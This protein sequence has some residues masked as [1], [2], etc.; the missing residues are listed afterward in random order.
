[1]YASNPCCHYFIER[2]QAP[3]ESAPELL[4]T[5][6]GVANVTEEDLDFSGRTFRILASP[7]Q[8]SCYACG[9]LEADRVPDVLRVLRKVYPDLTQLVFPK[10]RSGRKKVSD[11]GSVSPAHRLAF[12]GVLADWGIDLETFLLDGRYLLVI[13]GPDDLLGDMIKNRLFDI[14]SVTAL[15]DLNDPALLEKY[16]GVE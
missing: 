1:M 8:K 6:E 14:D 5:D 3:P 9:R 15:V 4:L 11:F 10:V 12:Q 7:F 13:D 2:K 16:E